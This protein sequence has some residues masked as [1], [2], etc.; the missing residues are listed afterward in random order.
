MATYPPTGLV[1]WDDELKAYVDGKATE[2]AA[3][4]LAAASAAGATAGTAAGTTAGTA[5]GTAAANGVLGPAQTAATSAAASAVSA[6]AS[7]SLAMSAAVDASQIALGDADAT[8]ATAINNPASETASALSAS[9][10]AAINEQVPPLIDTESTTLIQNRFSQPG[11][12]I[13]DLITSRSVFTCTAYRTASLALTHNDDTAIPFTVNQ[14]DTFEAQVGLPA[15]SGTNLPTRFTIPPG[16]PDGYLRFTA[17]VEFG[18]NATGTRILKVVKNGSIFC[19][20]SQQAAP[21]SGNLPMTV[22]TRPIAFTADDYFEVKAYQNSGGL[23]D[24]YPNNANNSSFGP[25]VSGFEIIGFPP[26]TDTDDPNEAAQQTHFDALFAANKVEVYE[27][28]T[29]VETGWKPAIGSSYNA[30]WTRDHAYTVWHA[31]DRVDW[32][33]LRQWVN[34]RIAKRSTGAE[35]GGHGSNGYADFIPDRIDLDG[36]AKFKNPSSSERPFM[37]GIHFLILA[38]WTDW[39]TNGHT[40]TFTANKT[41]ID[42]CLAAIPRDGSGAVYSDP[43][44][45]SV[46]YGFTDSILKTGAVAYGTALQAW[47]YKMCA[48]ISTAAGDTAGA[49]EYTTLK[50]TAMAG[51]AT[52]RRGDG[53]YNASSVNNQVED[54]WATALAVAENLIADSGERTAS[55]TVIRDRYVDAGI[56]S[57]GWA[58]HLIK[59]TFWTG[60]S[61]GQTA[62][63]NGGFWLTPLPDLV[64]AVSL[65]D[66]TKA[67]QWRNIAM[68]QVNRQI[69][70]EPSLGDMTAPYEWFYGTTYSEPRGYSASA[71]I[72][73]SPRWTSRDA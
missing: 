36:T 41:A 35:T 51:L 29:L 61:T 64:Y 70:R 63:Q 57:N 21:A 48:A 14:L 16:V 18:P 53:W 19:G 10:E 33:Q 1:G 34:H 28:A 38:M 40:A 44:T 20:V 32:T 46:D 56:V 66:S 65:V 13:R 62:Y 71:A 24:I 60:T 59:G 69:A 42:A 5:A 2:E 58:P 52:L 15:H 17:S 22:T 54:V 12:A 67:T 23:L 73:G 9:T 37:D 55:A 45:P 11:T 72:S 25:I 3:E 7:A 31:P 30:L 6:S 39:K 43:A 47:A 8:L 68:N 26:V 4:V 50:N 27:G 49:S